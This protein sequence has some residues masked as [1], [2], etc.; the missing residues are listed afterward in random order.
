M[1]SLDDQPN[2]RQAQA[3]TRASPCAPCRRA[4][5]ARTAGR[6]PR[7]GLPDRRSR[8]AATLALRL[9]P[10]VTRIQPPLGRCAESA[11][12]TRLP[13][14]R[15][16]KRGSPVVRAGPASISIEIDRS[17]ASVST[18]SSTDGTSVARSTGS[19]Y[20]KFAAS[21]RLQARESQQRADQPLRT[22]GCAKSDLAHSSQLVI[23]R[24]WVGQASRRA[25]CGSPTAGY[26]VRGWRWPRTAADCRTR[27]RGGQASRRKCRRARAIRR[28]ARRD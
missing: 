21:T 1:V 5:T 19:T 10:H 23:G 12:S 3:R 24:L 8:R 14:R 18:P 2:D 17:F 6:H 11:F 13:I 27:H 28:R 15:S 16:S 7:A 4:E 20:L 26:A 9:A 25:R 22:F